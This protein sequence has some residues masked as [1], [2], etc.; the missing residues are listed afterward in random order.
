MTVAFLSLNRLIDPYQFSQLSRLGLSVN[1]L[2]ATFSWPKKTKC[3]IINGLT[4][5][6]NRPT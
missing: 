2:S 4:Y 1:R 6:F 5:H 3:I